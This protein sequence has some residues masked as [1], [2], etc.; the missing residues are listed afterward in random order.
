MRD[1][2]GKLKRVL[3]VAGLAAV[4]VGSHGRAGAVCAT[5]RIQVSPRGRSDAI[6][7]SGLAGDEQQP[8]GRGS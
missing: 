4:V 1:W 6:G 5:V 3:A 8:G 2:N 7:V